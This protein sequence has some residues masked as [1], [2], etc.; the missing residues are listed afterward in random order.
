MIKP[1]FNHSKHSNLCC[2][3]DILRISATQRKKANSKKNKQAASLQQQC[4]MFLQ[5]IN[6][7]YLSTSEVWLESSG[8][9]CLL[10]SSSSDCT[11]GTWRCKEA[12]ERKEDASSYCLVQL[13]PV[14]FPLCCWPIP[15]SHLLFSDTQ[16]KTNPILR[17]LTSSGMTRY[18]GNA[19]RSLLKAQ[20]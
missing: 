1:S 4:I 18:K 9:E 11:E 17:P 12:W 15:C 13:Q 3:C 14:F 16:A 19:C 5:V 20:Y 7:K 8:W 6:H 2:L 10:W